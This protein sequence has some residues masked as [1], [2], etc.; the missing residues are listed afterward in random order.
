MATTKPSTMRNG[1]KF[2]IGL[3]AFAMAV[4]IGLRFYL[5]SEKDESN[6]LHQQGL[7]AARVGLG[8]SQEG[9]KLLAQEEQGELD[10]IYNEALQSLRQEERQRFFSLAQKG[11]GTTDQEL[12]ES[13]ALMQK[14]LAA[15][16]QERRDRL[17]AL[18]GKAV[19]LAQQKAASEK[20]PE[21]Q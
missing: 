4:V 16:P 8:L 15:L 11:T 7:P 9:R 1:T 3:L 20:K 12:S 6:V 2:V 21:G 10:S 14:A 19:Q 5:A 17:L 18:V 13:W